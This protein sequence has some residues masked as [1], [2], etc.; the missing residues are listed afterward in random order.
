M[1][2]KKYKPHQLMYEK[3]TVLVDFTNERIEPISMVNEYLRQT[4]P[5]I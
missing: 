5:N 4:K 1:R 2:Q 3:K